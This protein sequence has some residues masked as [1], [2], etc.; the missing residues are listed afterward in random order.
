M[1]ILKNFNRAKVKK[2][3]YF[4]LQG[5]KITKGTVI[6]LLLLNYNIFIQSLLKEANREAR[7]KKSKLTRA[8]HV[9]AVAKRIVKK[10]RK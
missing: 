10:Y 1:T 4:T 5:T 9:N 8:E 2:G 6:S 7:N 3:S